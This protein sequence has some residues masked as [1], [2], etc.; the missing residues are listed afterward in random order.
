MVYDDLTQ[1][2]LIVPV[3]ILKGHTP[4]AGGLGVMDCQFHPRQPWIFSAGADGRVFLF[5]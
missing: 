5:T 3:K 1:N 4:T 2:A